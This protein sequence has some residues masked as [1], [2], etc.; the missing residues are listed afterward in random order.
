[1]RFNFSSTTEHKKRNNI[2]SQTIHIYQIWSQN[3]TRLYPS[4][5]LLKHRSPKYIVAIIFDICLFVG[6]NQNHI[7]SPNNPSLLTW[8]KRGQ[9]RKQS[10]SCCFTPRSYTLCFLTGVGY[11][12]LQQMSSCPAL[13]MEAVHKRGS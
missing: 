4:T 1:M 6:A 13:S 8:Q 11:W 9:K 5:K 10:L 2:I 12:L 3:T 7:L